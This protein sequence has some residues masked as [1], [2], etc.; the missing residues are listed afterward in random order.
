MNSVFGSV[1]GFDY[2][3][4]I[5]TENRIKK[6]RF[7]LVLANSVHLVVRFGSVSVFGLFGYFGFSAHP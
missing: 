6:V 4:H 1:F 5:Q 3:S 2:Q 7:G